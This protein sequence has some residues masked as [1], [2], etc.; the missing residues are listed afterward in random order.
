MKPG[1]RSQLDFE[2]VTDGEALE[3]W[4]G[5]MMTIPVARTN[6]AAIA[7]IAIPAPSNFGE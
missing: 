3:G 5:G 1:G 2:T 6:S 4:L 7:V